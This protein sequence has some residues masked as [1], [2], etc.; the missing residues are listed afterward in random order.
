[1]E[2]CRNCESV[3]RRRCHTPRSSSAWAHHCWACARNQEPRQLSLG[4]HCG[5][6]SA[7]QPAVHDGELITMLITVMMVM[8]VTKMRSPVATIRGKPAQ[9]Q[10]PSTAKSKS[11]RQR[12]KLFKKESLWIQLYKIRKTRDCWQQNKANHSQNKMESIFAI[13]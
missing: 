6:P 1:M 9:R 12:T 2:S 4:P 13:L 7:P 10:R 5:R 8:M 11:T 3:H